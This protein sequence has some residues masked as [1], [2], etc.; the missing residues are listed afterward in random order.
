M[1][2]VIVKKSEFDYQDNLKAFECEELRL[3]TLSLN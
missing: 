1:T 3:M 2:Q